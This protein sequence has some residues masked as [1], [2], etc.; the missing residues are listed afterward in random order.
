MPSSGFV[1]IEVQ[2]LR[3]LTKVLTLTS[4]VAAFGI[5]C[6]TCVDAHTVAGPEFG[7]QRAAVAGPA[8]VVGQHEGA[9]PVRRTHGVCSGYSPDRGVL[10]VI[11]LV[12]KLDEHAGGNVRLA[13]DGVRQDRRRSD[14]DEGGIDAARSLVEELSW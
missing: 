13:G 2:D 1:Q 11:V 5:E 6:H 7:H 12:D 9:L 14:I 10:D 8:A 3:D 4:S